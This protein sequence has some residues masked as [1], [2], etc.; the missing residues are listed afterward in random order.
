[1]KNRE[2]VKNLDYEIEKEDIYVIKVED[3]SR[4]TFRTILLDVIETDVVDEKGHLL[5]FNVQN[6]V[7]A[8]SPPELRGK[9]GEKYPISIL[10]DNIETPNMMYKILKGNGENIYTL[11]SGSKLIIKVNIKQVDRTSLYNRMGMPTYIVRSE[12][13]IAQEE[14]SL[15]KE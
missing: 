13:M 7:T 12:T 14:T 11:E 9:K 4:I 6:L 10:E 8:L 5:Q 2:L 15:V 1:M 3:G